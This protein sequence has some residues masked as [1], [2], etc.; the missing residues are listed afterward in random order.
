MD[1]DTDPFTS[2]YHITEFKDR[3]RAETLQRKE[4]EKAWKEEREAEEKAKKVSCSRSLILYIPC[5]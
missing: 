3:Q 5:S 2:T 4:R 1:G